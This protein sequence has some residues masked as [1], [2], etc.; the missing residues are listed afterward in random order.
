MKNIAK[1][2]LSFFVIVSLALTAALVKAEESEFKDYYQSKSKTVNGDFEAFEIGT[3]LSETQLEGA[4][5][6]VSFDNPSIISEVDGSH[7]LDVRG[8]SKKY[9]SAFLMLPD[10]LEV[11]TILRVTYDV[12][13]AL[14]E[15]KSTYEY[16]DVA[17][18]GGAN[19]EYYKNDFKQMDFTQN[20]SS[21]TRGAETVNYPINVT[22]M[23]N[24]W[25]HVVFDVVITRN[26]LIQTN[27]I[28]FLA[29]FKSEEDHLY[30]DN[31]NLYYL[32]EE[33]F[34]EK[35]EVSSITIAD[36]AQL[37]LK[38]NGSKKLEYTVNPENATDKSVTFTSSDETVA[39]VSQ[40]GTVTA[41]KAGSTVVTVKAENGVKAQIAVIVSEESSSEP[42][43][44]EELPP[45]A[46]EGCK[47]EIVSS[48][49]G[50][51]LILGATI[52]ISKKRKER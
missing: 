41:L 12:K 28:R 29:I 17:F 32:Q 38:V 39:T 51:T 37:D 31:V 2:F 1:V 30:F 47:G 50:A 7:V 13:L 40:D 34:V 52:V 42:G 16:M 11:G 33:P 43:G 4:W 49:I 19:V 36:G 24:G 46:K 6:T 44:N 10:T 21:I 35:V 8:G 27:S 20:S 5:G 48:L 23:E 18:V 22:V 15:D 25:C 3:T 14:T 45:A 9:S 26:D